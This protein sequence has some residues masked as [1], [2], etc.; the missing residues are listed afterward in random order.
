MADLPAWKDVFDSDLWYSHYKFVLYRYRLKPDQNPVIDVPSI[1]MGTIPSNYEKENQPIA[2]GFSAFLYQGSESER[3]FY[4]WHE[5]HDNSINVNF[6]DQYYNYCWIHYNYLYNSDSVYNE[7][8]AFKAEF[9]LTHLRDEKQYLID[10][11]KFFIETLDAKDSQIKSKMQDLASEYIS[12]LQE[13]I[14]VLTQESSESPAQL[15]N[16]IVINDKTPSHADKRKKHQ[17]NTLRE[18]WEKDGDHYEYIIDLL[19]NHSFK[20]LD[21]PFV[22]DFEG[23]LIWNSAEHMSKSYLFGFIYTCLLN[24]WISSIHSSTDYLRIIKNTFNIKV[25][26][27][28]YKSALAKAISAE[29]SKYATYLAPFKTSAY[30]EKI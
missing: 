17:Y 29:N 12:F 18:I 9:L 23:R 22:T 27:G 3:S 30:L 19:C 25:D 1:D 2:F 24:K 7:P 4:N 16:T 13:K 20:R 8:V 14:D 5:L 6:K 10:S 21:Y 28:P 15:Q 11:E 26:P